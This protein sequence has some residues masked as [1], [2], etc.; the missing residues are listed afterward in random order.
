MGIIPREEKRR[1][2]QLVKDYLKKTKEGKYQ[3][4]V[5]ELCEKYA[6][7]QDGKTFPLSRVRIHQLLDKQGVVNKRSNNRKPA[8]KRAN[9]IA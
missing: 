8:K 2:K 4:T 7:L 9:K 3:Y 1:N 6:R 5:T